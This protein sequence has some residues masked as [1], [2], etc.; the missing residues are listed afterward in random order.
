MKKLSLGFFGFVLVAGL[1][2]G[3]ARADEADASDQ[4]LD[5][6]LTLDEPVEPALTYLDFERTVLE[7]SA[8]RSR[9]ALIGTSAAAAVGAALFFPLAANCIEISLV[10]GAPPKCG[11]GAEA[12]VVI[13]TMVLTG[14]MVG[15]IVTGIMYGVRKGKL[16]RLDDRAKYGR[17]RAVRFDADRGS[18]VF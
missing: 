2:S 17:G 16:R 11:R 15:T 8:R 13:S 18:F 9:N 12:G 6:T 3:Q 5:L 1:W 14:G 4:E 7:E 10:E